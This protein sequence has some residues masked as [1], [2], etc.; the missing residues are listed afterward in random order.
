MKNAKFGDV[1]RAF[2][3]ILQSLL[4]ASYLGAYRYYT[5]EPIKRI[6]HYQDDILR[7]KL[8]NALVDFRRIKDEELSFVA[9]AV[10]K[11]LLNPSILKL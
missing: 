5:L 11:D 1:P 3:R 4:T 6:E 2:G 8:I 10:S 9:K 7:G